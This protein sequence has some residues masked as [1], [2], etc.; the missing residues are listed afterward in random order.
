MIL[1]ASG[2]GVLSRYR[3]QSLSAMAGVR[4]AQAC[5]KGTVDFL[6]AATSSLLVGLVAARALEAVDGAVGRRP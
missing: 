6:T 5:T 4:A 2:R 3:V 1:K